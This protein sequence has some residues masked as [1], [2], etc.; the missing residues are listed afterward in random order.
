MGPLAEFPGSRTQV[1]NA[2]PVRF[3]LPLPSNPSPVTFAKKAGEAFHQFLPH[4]ARKLSIHFRGLRYP[5]LLLHKPH[6][7]SLSDQRDR[8]KVRRP[9]CHGLPTAG[10]A[11][12]GGG[13]QCVRAQ[14]VA[15][16]IIVGTDDARAS[17]RILPLGAE[18]LNP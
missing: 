5:Q 12:G 2:P 14:L 3:L 15:G 7:T 10:G 8:F 16:I 11:A 18:K 1:I 17:Y 13:W 4:K 6:P 9:G